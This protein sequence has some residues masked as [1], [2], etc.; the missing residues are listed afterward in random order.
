LAARI[1]LPANGEQATLTRNN[2]I[3]NRIG[4]H[5]ARIKAA[6]W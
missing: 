1:D 4:R 6:R 2:P 3:D 5:F